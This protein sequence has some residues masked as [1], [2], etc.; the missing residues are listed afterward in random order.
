LACKG[1]A[2]AASVVEALDSLDRL[3]VRVKA[4]DLAL[5]QMKFWLEMSKHIL[6]DC[7]KAL[8]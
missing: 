6:K 5:E 8:L 2:Q 3:K 7:E 1:D 4:K